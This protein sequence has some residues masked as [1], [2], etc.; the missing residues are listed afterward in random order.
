MNLPDLFN[1][2]TNQVPEKEI[3]L[4]CLTLFAKYSSYLLPKRNVIILLLYTIK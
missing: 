4:N 3:L 1:A 2:Y